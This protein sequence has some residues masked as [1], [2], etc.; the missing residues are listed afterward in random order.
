M[1]IGYEEFVIPPILQKTTHFLLDHLELEGLFRV[2]GSQDEIAIWKEQFNAG[3]PVEFSGKMAPHSVAGLLKAWLREL[4]E[5][6]LTYQ[7]FDAWMDIA[8]KR[9]K[10]SEKACDLIKSSLKALPDINMA[11]L[12]EL[13]LFLRK[14]V[15]N[16]A[17]NLM[18]AENVGVV[19]GPNI[20]SKENQDAITS[21]TVMPAAVNLAAFLVKHADTLFVGE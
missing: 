21:A 13:F 14:V 18:T 20:L 2:S 17:K 12:T 11:V 15:D 1:Y 19:I 5:P 4:P 7:M 8:T 16:S 6:L 3:K 9:L 10:K